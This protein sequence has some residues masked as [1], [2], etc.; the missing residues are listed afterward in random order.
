[1]C[2]G[3][4]YP[5]ICPISPTPSSLLKRP[6][7]LLISP[8]YNSPSHCPHRLFSYLIGNFPLLTCKIPS[9]PSHISAPFPTPASLHSK[10]L[11][12]LGFITPVLQ[13]YHSALCLPHSACAIPGNIAFRWSNFSFLGLHKPIFSWIFHLMAQACFSIKG[14]LKIINVL[15]FLLRL[16]TIFVIGMEDFYWCCNRL[17]GV[18]T[19]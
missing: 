11:R 13:V 1:M 17:E 4:N 2:H 16:N 9:T 18:K 14:K 12:V 10:P 6:A 19:C 15:L 8:Q 5:K 7:F 3:R